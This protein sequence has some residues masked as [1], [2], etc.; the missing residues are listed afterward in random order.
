MEVQVEE[1]TPAVEEAEEQIAQRPEDNFDSL[2]DVFASPLPTPRLASPTK[3]SS[4]GVP[5]RPMSAAST[6]AGPPTDL[7]SK[8]AARLM[9][10]YRTALANRTSSTAAISPSLTTTALPAGAQT[11]SLRERLQKE[12]DLATGSSSSSAHLAG[13]VTVFSEETRRLLLARLE[14]EKAFVDQN[15]ADAFMDGGR[16]QYDDAWQGAAAWDDAEQW[17][18]QQQADDSGWA[19]ESTTP[20]S[21]PFMPKVIVPPPDE[22]VKESALRRL[23]LSKRAATG[24]S[25]VASAATTTTS[26]PTDP[27]DQQQQDLAA[28][29]GDLKQ[30]LLKAKLMKMRQ[31]ASA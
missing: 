28:R 19:E 16:A 18:G 29:S 17:Q 6:S 14:E 3:P 30:K 26:T 9:A 11:L 2:S 13:G 12:K 15:G 20:P 10:E 23:L 1:A 27:V 8:L 22:D 5:A 4:L 31:V 21:P 24:P 7:R 25:L